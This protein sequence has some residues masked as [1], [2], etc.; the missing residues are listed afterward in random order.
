MYQLKQCLV[1]LGALLL[2]SYCNQPMDQ[3]GP[4]KLEILLLGH[5]S[6][7]HNSEAY[8]PLLASA[9]TPKGF[10][11]SYSSD[12]A[13]LNEA[14]LQRYDALMVYA[15]HDEIEPAQEK[16]LLQFV[17]K[18]GGL[19]PIH[20][21]SFCFRNSD[22]YVEL[23]GG[24]FKSHET[25]TF[26]AEIIAP[27]HPAM[28]GVD[29]FETWDETYVHDLHTQDRTVLMERVEGD[30][31]EPYTWV[32]EYGK[33]RMFYT[34]LGHD[35]RTWSK[36]GFHRLLEQGILWA[37]GEQKAEALA[38]LSFPERT[39][40]EAIIP[41]YEKRDPAPLL[42]APLDVEASQQLIQIPPGFELEL[43]A[44]EPDIVNPICMNWDERGRL[45]IV[46]TR[47][48]PNEINTTLLEGNDKIKI[49]EDTDGD[50]KAD[51]F[52]VFAEGLSVPTSL[53]FSN[54]G[55]IVSQAPYF[56]FLKDTDGDDKADVKEVLMKGWGT[57]D[58]HAGPSNL[59]YGF[60]NQI[61]GVVGY[62]AYDG[63]VGTDTLKF[64]QAA[65]R[66]EPDG[67]GMEMMGK[68]S[69]NTWGLGFSETFDVFIS[70]ANN[71]HSGY[72]G[73]PNRLLSKA[74]GLNVKGVQKIDG[75]YAFHTVTQNFRQVD[76]FGGFTAAA[77]HQLYTARSFPKDYWNRIALVCEPTGHL[78]HQAIIEKDGAGFKEKDGWNLLASADEWVSP[79]QASVGP[80]GAVWILDWY[81]F[82]IQ[83]NPTPT[84]FENGNGNAHINP[85]RDKQH[86]RIYRLR[87]KASAPEPAM[88]LSAADKE[89]LLAGLR[90]SNMLWRMHAQ[91]LIVE[92]GIEGLEEKLYAIV[93]NT[94]VDEIGLNSPA[95][96]A[97]WT[98]HGLGLITEAHP[99][100]LAVAHEALSHPAAGVRK[101]ALMC[102]PKN[103]KEL[104]V[105]MAAG[106]F[107]DPDLH[108]RLA[109]VVALGDMPSADLVGENLYE[110]SQD[111]IVKKDDWLSRAVY[112]AAAKHKASFSK[113]LLRAKAELLA[114]LDSEELGG[115]KQWQ[116]PELDES[117]WA[118]IKVPARWEVAAGR[119]LERFDGT[120]WYRRKIELTDEQAAEGATISLGMV[121]DTDVTFINGQ[122]V[123]GMSNNVDDKRLYSIKR[124]VLKAGENTIA[125]KVSDERWRGG[126]YGDI[127]DLFLQVGQEK[128]DLSGEWKYKV[129]KVIRSSQS[130]FA[131]GISVE[132]LFIKHYGPYAK[133]IVGTGTGDEQAVDREIVIKTIPEQ[134]K[135]DV[136]NLA[137]K[138]GETVAIVFENIDAMQHN[139][140]IGAI[141]SLDIIG[142]A[143]DLLAQRG[144]ETVDYIPNIPQ[145][146]AAT[147]LVNS[148]ESY[149]L[150]FKVPQEAG[151]YP[152]VCTF[153]GHWRMM[154][155]VIT[156]SGGI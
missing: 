106:I 40:S 112:A 90:H 69:N 3:S 83:H 88:A 65:Y 35:E 75:H 7:H 130:I 133:K 143:A 107:K 116:R 95:V 73:V 66:F 86:G 49:L 79:V 92:E 81:N 82:I 15:N 38:Q 136:T 125:I 47:D 17:K 9:L 152:Y 28:K 142:E 5:D 131:S 126:I 48:Y 55:V 141:G 72:L 32:K 91:R 51:K 127:A 101:A 39:Y 44:S 63:I 153:P 74:E 1:L 104:N 128:L 43:F 12:L 13:D 138:A 10:N 105:L 123:G 108:T 151:E 56:L 93:A 36:P 24:Q 23:V 94:T 145:V 117:D 37:V 155:G 27:D 14:N 150:I 25:G 84:G 8:L 30:E 144:G 4:R 115:D 21:A 149:R 19:L 62:S 120:L 70:T 67:S 147:P 61:W 103:E 71:T 129:E 80:D 50:G 76:V 99:A 113:A 45:W 132:D 110:L 18:G 114:Q 111:P 122:Q 59:Q 64:S 96:H 68:T 53:V 146:L 22:E 77:G 20:S 156:V 98:M 46:E 102:L 34:A 41:N 11:F 2:F 29:A 16:A 78:L 26:T 6:E 87:H 148:G 52:T 139:L 31:R 124:G 137:L 42:Q 135:Y 118:P 154:N 89:G 121:D 134:M 33:G 100:A 60:D 97:L 85:L 58:T 54:G 57:S 140:L 119:A 109:A